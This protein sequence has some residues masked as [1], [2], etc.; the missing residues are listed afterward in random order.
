M[1]HRWNALYRESHHLWANFS[2]DWSKCLR[3]LSR[4]HP[5]AAAAVA[6]LDDIFDWVLHRAPLFNTLEYTGCHVLGTRLEAHLAQ[7]LAAA[8]GLQ[9]VT[10]ADAAGTLDGALAPLSSVAALR[11]LRVR[12]HQPLRGVSKPLRVS[13]GTLCALHPLPALRH[14]ELCV[15]QVMGR[16]ADLAPW[17]ALRALTSLSLGCR[18]EAALVHPDTLCALS[19]LRRLE[20]T[21]VR[22][23][24]FSPAIVA[25][26]AGV[27]H[28]SLS[29]VLAATPRR[30]SGFTMWHALRGLRALETLVVADA[31]HDAELPG[32]ALACPALTAL[33]LLRCSRLGDWQPGASA[34]TSSSSNEW[35]ALGMLQE[36]HLEDVGL[37]EEAPEAFW[38]ALSALTARCWREVRR[39]RP[40]QQAWDT[41]GTLRI[42]RQVVPVLGALRSLRYEYG[43]ALTAG[44]AAAEAEP[45]AAAAAEPPP[46]SLDQVLAA[47]T[48]LRALSLEGQAEVFACGDGRFHFDLTALPLERLSLNN[49]QLAEVPAPVAC[50]STL[51]ELSLLDNPRLTVDKKTAESL[52][53]MRRVL[54][55]DPQAVLEKETGSGGGSSGG[56][57]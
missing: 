13:V 40:H 41:G 20:L 56:A 52:R 17:P 9:S 50:H 28:L 39:A 29:G 45:D 26:L 22:L 1:C 2:F 25:A 48:S 55:N 42:P 44:G 33:T 37:L 6:K 54:R 5:D 53:R 7:V 32:A 21:N 3:A 36:L 8:P 38:R 12:W 30:K 18:M 4:R 14:L 16:A 51:Q 19:S 57:E 24:Q 35:K 23:P 10:L 15:D 49:C 43:G 11:S 47:C 46:P 31:G 27:T 34:T